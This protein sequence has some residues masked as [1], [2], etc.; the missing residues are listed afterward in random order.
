VV[1]GKSGPAFDS[2]NGYST[3][4][5]PD[6]MRVAYVAKQE[7]KPCVVVDEKPGP[8]YDEIVKFFFSPDSNHIAYVAKQ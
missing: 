2:I 6:S 1:D 8:T 4:F 5:S 7:K 3:I